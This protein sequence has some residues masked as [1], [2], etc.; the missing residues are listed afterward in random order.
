MTIEEKYE[1]FDAYLD[2]S[3]SPKD[4]NIFEGL[5]LDI[6][7]H[8]EFEDYKNIQN[9]FI[10]ISKNET[11]KKI[12]VE[13]VKNI[14]NNYNEINTSTIGEKAE[15][16]KEYINAQQAKRKAKKPRPKINPFSITRNIKLSFAAAA[17]MVIS[18][19]ILPKLFAPKQDMQSLFA[20]NYEPEKLSLE[21]G[22]NMDSVYTIATLFNAKKYNETTPILNSYI[23]AHPTDYRLKLVLA[24]CELEQNNFANTELILQNV[25]ADN[26][27][28]K[29]KAQWY[30]AMTYLKQNKKDK[31]CELA[32]SFTT[33][34]FFYKKAQAIL[35]NLK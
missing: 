14:S 31:V 26:N 2:N 28:Y 11:D 7:T 6:E 15:N 34:H 35:K 27:T 16:K 32:N 13:N 33:D 4:K 22:G 21:R 23:T 20:S 5:M 25:I 19:M 30:L 29:E 18:F 17:L 24:M 3:L 10:T 1:L 8:K 12:F 9:A